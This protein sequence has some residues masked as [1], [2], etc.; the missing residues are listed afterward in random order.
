MDNDD[1]AGVQAARAGQREAVRQ[2]AAKLTQEIDTD[3][4]IGGWRVD[5]QST[6]MAAQLRYIEQTGNLPEFDAFDY[7]V[8]AR[9]VL[10]ATC[11]EC[12]STVARLFISPSTPYSGFRELTRYA[13]WVPYQAPHVMNRCKHTGI[14]PTPE[15]TD[16]FVEVARALSVPNVRGAH[17][18][19]PELGNGRVNLQ[20]SA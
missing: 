10:T 8:K 12:H 16:I 7:K 1:W 4:T 18:D 20:P 6:Y 2:L 5:E 14:L 15:T 9:I 11:A 3:L 13:Y 19:I 17:G